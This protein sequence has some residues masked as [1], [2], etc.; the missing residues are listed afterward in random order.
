M[1]AMKSVASKAGDQ[2]HG[3]LLAECEKLRQKCN[4][5]T[6]DERRQARQRALKIIYGTN[7]TKPAGRR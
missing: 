1:L 6:D 2:S 7:A 4:K 3:Q 5:M